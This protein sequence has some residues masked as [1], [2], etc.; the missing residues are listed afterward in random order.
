MSVRRNAFLVIQR[1][2]LLLVSYLLIYFLSDNKINSLSLAGFNRFLSELQV[3]LLVVHL[4][5]LTV[6]FLRITVFLLR[7]WFYYV[8]SV[9]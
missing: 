5:E 9:C 6:F 2:Y 1:Y 7:L 3:Y 8:E 4:E